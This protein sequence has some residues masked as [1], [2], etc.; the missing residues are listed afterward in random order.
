M[1]DGH[2]EAWIGSVKKNKGYSGISALC[3]LTSC[4][5]A[6]NLVMISDSSMSG[7]L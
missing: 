1:K 4:P 6:I 3:S 5:I 7:I 2:K